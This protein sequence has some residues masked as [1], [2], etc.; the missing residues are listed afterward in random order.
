LFLL[1]CAGCVAAWNIWAL[2]VFRAI[3]GL[4]G[5]VF[6]L[7]FAI[8]HDEL[9]RERVGLGLAMI[10]SVLGV[11]AGLGVVFGGVSTDPLGRRW[12]FVLGTAVAALALVLVH[13]R[14]PESRVKS[15]S[16][17]DVPGALLLAAA[18]LALLV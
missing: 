1:G 10:G 8:V 5:A 12:I 2:I 17:V 18:L 16:R 3:A 6:P 15:P 7:S 4:G 11:G 14:V 9:P 13:R